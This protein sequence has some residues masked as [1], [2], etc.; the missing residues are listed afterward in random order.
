[1]RLVRRPL[2]L[3]LVLA[4]AASVAGAQPSALPFVESEEETAGLVVPRVPMHH[5][6]EKLVSVD[7]AAALIL[8]ENAVVMQLTDD[9]VAQA[10]YAPAPARRESRLARFLS[11]LLPG[12]ARP[13]P[14]HAVRC[15]LTRVADVKVGVDG[16][17]V[18]TVNDGRPI[19]V[20]GV[21]GSHGRFDPVEARLFAA[22]VKA[23]ANAK[24]SVH[25]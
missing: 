24:R 19:R 23:A 21:H 13:A 18:L 22:R 5:A 25:D 12:R 3:L 7:G 15:E 16:R 6:T 9:G 20:T 14:E 8:T 17:I 11:S 2:A 1:M 4:A 10:A